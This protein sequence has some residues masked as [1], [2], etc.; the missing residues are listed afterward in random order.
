MPAFLLLQNIAATSKL[1][2]ALWLCC[3]I[4]LALLPPPD[5]KIITFFIIIIY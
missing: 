5:A 2:S 3:Q 1:H 4:A